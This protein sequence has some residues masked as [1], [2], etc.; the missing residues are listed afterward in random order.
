MKNISLIV[1]HSI[2]HAIG[3]DNKIPW[4]CPEDLKRFKKF[5]EHKTVVMGRKTFESIGKSLPNRYN[6]IISRNKDY[7]VKGCVVIN[8]LTKFLSSE[9]TQIGDS[10]VFIIGGE[11]IY[12]E[13]LPF[14]NKIYLTVVATYVPNAD[15]YFIA[16]GNN[17]TWAVDADSVYIHDDV[18]EGETPFSFCILNRVKL[19][20]NY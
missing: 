1:A 2:D 18:K 5:T 19:D 11:S 6:V 20:E 17:D 12:K 7:K 16:L 4:Y 15:A 8:D 9:F 3:K 10:E 14:A 13:A